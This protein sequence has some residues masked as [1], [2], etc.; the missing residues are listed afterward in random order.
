MGE[1]WWKLC[2]QARGVGLA[3]WQLFGSSPFT[4]PALRYQAGWAV[5]EARNAV[6]RLAQR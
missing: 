2:R 6:R 3:R 1:Y 5:D 4:L